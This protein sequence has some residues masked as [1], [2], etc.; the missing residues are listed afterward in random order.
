MSLSAYDRALEEKCKE[1]FANS[2]IVHEDRTEDATDGNAELLVPLISIWRL[3]NPL[4]FEGWANTAVTDLGHFYSEGKEGTRVKA[5][6]IRVLYQISIISDKRK[7]VDDIFRELAMFLFEENTLTVCFDSA[8]EGLP[9][10]KRDFTIKMLDNNDLT[11]Y[12]SFGDKGRLYREVINIEI[13]NGKLIFEKR[14]KTV[15]EIPV[16]TYIMEGEEYESN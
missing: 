7:E 12:A 16:R 6:P 15:L 3:G 4:D 10:I 8:I 11:D 2:K 14:E 5:L 9:P 13:P 1:V